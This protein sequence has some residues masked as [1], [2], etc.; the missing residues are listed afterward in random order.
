V[1]SVAVSN[2]GA[3][4]SAKYC[5]AGSATGRM[6]L[7]NLQSGYLLRVWEAHYKAVTCIKFTSDDA[8]VVSGSEDS[9]V[10]VWSMADL[11]D[12]GASRYLQPELSDEKRSSSSSHSHAAPAVKPF[13][14]WSDHSLSVTGIACSLTGSAGRI[15]TCSLDHT[16][17]IWDLFTKQL[18]HTITL[19]TFLNGIAF[20]PDECTIAVAGGGDRCVY[21]VDL[22]HR[23]SSGVVVG[24][25]DVSAPKSSSSSSSSS[26]HTIRRLVGHEK[27]VRSVTFSFDGT[28]VVSVCAG[29]R[30]NVWDTTTTQCVRVLENHRKQYT[31]IHVFHDSVGF[32]LGERARAVA[33]QIVVGQLA[34]YVTP[35]AQIVDH[36]TRVR[37]RD[38]DAYDSTTAASASSKRRRISHEHSS[39][40]ASDVD[41]CSNMHSDA[42]DITIQDQSQAGELAQ[43]KAATSK[44]Y[45]ACV[46]RIFDQVASTTAPPS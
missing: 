34:K 4:S 39:A 45:T 42:L 1:L 33:D 5:V 8:F 27:P 29:G 35:L 16:V 40:S 10:C 41:L 13:V 14:Q 22:V 15:V 3:A 38:D 19:P 46:D 24:S 18:V 9:L 25:D 6:Y 44:L 23:A 30:M 11:L 32:F 2:C 31:D 17:K 7:W 28:R 20:A 12:I 21:L 36:G 37:L 26:S 43:W